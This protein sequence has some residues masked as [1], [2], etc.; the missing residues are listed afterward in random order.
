MRFLS[1]LLL[2]DVCVCGVYMHV[3]VWS[4]CEVVLVP[5]VDVVVAVMRVLFF[6]L[7]V[8]MLR[9]C[10]GDGNAVLG[11]AEVWLWLVRGVSIW[12]Y[13]WFRFVSTADDVIGMSVVR[14]VRVVGGVCEICMCLA[15]GVVG[16][17]GMSVLGL[18][19]TNSIRTGGVWH[20]CLCLG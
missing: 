4:V 10:E 3:M 7:H 6:V 8:C 17:V 13:T 15:W 12:R 14:G 2:L 16:G 20:V 18:G 9:E 19:Y 1:R 11:P 5:Y